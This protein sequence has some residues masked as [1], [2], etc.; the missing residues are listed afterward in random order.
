MS[1]IPAEITELAQQRQAARAEK[2]FA[3]SDA[4]REDIAAHGWLIKDTPDGFVLSVAPPFTQYANAAALVDS[5]RDSVTAETVVLVIVDG[6]PEDTRRSLGALVSHLPANACVVGIDCGNVDSAGEVLHELALTDSRIHE[7]H[8]AQT[9][10]EV[11]WSTAVKA[12]IEM[13]DCEYIGVMDLSTI[14]DGDSLTPLLSVFHDSSVALTGWRGVN[15]NTEDEWRSFVDAPAGSVDAVLGYYM[16]MRRGVAREIGPHPKAKFYRNADM[17][18]SLALRAAGH[19]V[20]VPAVDLPVHQER[21][22]GYH[23]SD[24]EYRDQQS[25]KTYDRLLQSYRGKNHILHSVGGD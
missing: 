18:W 19:D 14:W 15:V 16:L 23:D 9:L 5:A 22:H 17:E 6:W 25:K 1:E 24:P 3:R 8:L 10:T 20:V 11:G 2:D 21:H 13:A 12:G 4:L 7:F